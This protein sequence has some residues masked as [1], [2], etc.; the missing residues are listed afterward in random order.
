MLLRL[1]RIATSSRPHP[2]VRLQPRNAARRDASCAMGWMVR[3]GACHGNRRRRP[4]LE[5]NGNGTRG[6]PNQTH[7][8][9]SVLGFRGIT[10]IENQAKRFSSRCVYTIEYVPARTQQHSGGSTAAEAGRQ[11]N[12]SITSPTTPILCH[13]AQPKRAFCSFL[14]SSQPSIATGYPV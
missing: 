7:L 2:G 3:L 9:F 12:S 5:A 13:W 8:K 1:N 6:E 4:P 10:E 14:A 11:S